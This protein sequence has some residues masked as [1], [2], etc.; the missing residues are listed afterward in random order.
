MIKYVKKL[1]KNIIINSKLTINLKLIITNF[2]I[3]IK[4]SNNK[5]K[6]SNIVLNQ[7]NNKLTQ[8]K[9]INENIKIV[10]K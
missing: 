10:N 7:K 4:V 3:L 9:K 2:A 5:Y 6:L 1:K 8:N